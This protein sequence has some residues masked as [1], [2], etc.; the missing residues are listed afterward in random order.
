MTCHFRTWFDSFTFLIFWLQL[1][2]SPDFIYIFRFIYIIVLLIVKQAYCFIL[3]TILNSAK[4]F[5]KTELEL[6]LELLIY[7]NQTCFKRISKWK[8]EFVNSTTFQH[9]NFDKNWIEQVTFWFIIFNCY[10]RQSETCYN[11]KWY[12]DWK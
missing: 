3:C 1:G 2:M 10:I 9:V 4:H 11:M 7:K 12:R 8:H 5:N 6:E